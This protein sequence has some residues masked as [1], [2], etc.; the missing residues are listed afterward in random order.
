MSICLFIGFNQI[1]IVKINLFINV[2]VHFM[3]KSYYLQ[4]KKQLSFLFTTA[5]KL[6]NNRNAVQFYTFTWHVAFNKAT[7][8][9][10]AY[11]KE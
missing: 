2:C 9:N 6:L 7:G 1:L 4:F 8:V 5:N 10:T 11:Q 3:F